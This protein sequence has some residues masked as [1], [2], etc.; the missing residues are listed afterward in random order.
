M[1]TANQPGPSLP[2]QLRNELNEVHR[3][4]LHVHKALIDHERMRYEREHG[5]VASAG[6]FLQILSPFPCSAGVRYDAG[7]DPT[8]QYSNIT[9]VSMRSAAPML[10]DLSAQ[11]LC[12]SAEL[13]D[14][15]HAVLDADPSV[16]ADAAQLAEDGIVVVE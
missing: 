6:E 15:F 5:R 1:T 14:S 2:D 3:G 7:E 8:C 13:F 9:I 16:E 11:K 10:C 4:L 12:A